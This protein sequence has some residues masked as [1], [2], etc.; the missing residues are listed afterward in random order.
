MKRE[1][2][3]DTTRTMKKKLKA[4]KAED[5]KPRKA[6]V[7]VVVSSKPMS[8]RKKIT[9]NSFEIWYSENK[10]S[11]SQ[12]YIEYVY[13]TRQASGTPLF[14]K[15]WAKTVYDSNRSL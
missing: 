5:H 8:T 11:L 9:E 7:N 2:E 6:K 1:V 15:A 12:D 13:E 3:T 10:S 4:L 14:L